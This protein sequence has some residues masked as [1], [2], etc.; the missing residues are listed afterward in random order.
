MKVI[1]KDEF[2]LRWAKPLEP[3]RY[4]VSKDKIEQYFQ[5]LKEAEVDKT[6]PSLIINIDEIGL[7]NRCLVG[8][9]RDL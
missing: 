7:V 8:S 9:D 4:D 1:Q 6:N 5:I 3:E 2:R